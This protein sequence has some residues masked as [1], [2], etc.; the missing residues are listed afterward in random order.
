MSGKCQPYLCITEQVNGR[1][2]RRADLALNSI[3]CYYQVIN[4]MVARH[5]TLFTSIR[6]ILLSAFHIRGS[7]EQLFMF[8][9][10][11]LNVN[12]THFFENLALL[13]KTWKLLLLVIIL[14]LEF[15]G[16]T[17]F[18]NIH[19]LWQLLQSTYLL[20][21]MWSTRPNRFMYSCL[22]VGSVFA[23]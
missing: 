15:N 20:V 9:K 4:V 19:W 16:I 8:R 2:D 17:S 14:Y 10:L 3:T 23:P 18:P 22:F 5:L 12:Q 1:T 7:E 11:G 21:L 13:Y 6:R